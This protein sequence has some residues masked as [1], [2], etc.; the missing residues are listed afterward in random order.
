MRILIIKLSSL[1]DVIHTLPALAALRK[2]YPRAHLSWLVEP[3]SAELLLDHPALDQVLVIPKNRWCREAAS[4]RR[5]PALG[6]EFRHFLHALRGVRY[7]I[8]LDFQGLLKSGVL[9][10][11]ARGKRK[12]GFAPGKERGDIFLNEKV[13]YPVEL[14]HAVRRYLLLTEHLACP[15]TTPSFSISL[16]QQHRNRVIAL[17]RQH[18]LA[19]QQPLVLLHPG[20]RW[21]S[22][23]WKEEHW[24]ALGDRLQDEL[25][26][27]VVFTGS[28]EDRALVERI[29]GRMRAPGVTTVGELDLKELAFLQACAE[30]VV[31]P[32]SGPMHLATAMG[33]PVVALF[34]PTDPALTGPFGN[35]RTVITKSLSCRPCL[36]R[37]CATNECMH[38]ISVQEVWEGVKATLTSSH[39]V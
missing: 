26:A 3:E 34:G 20:T 19:C 18:H 9:T 32:D 2:A 5:W 22:K 27:Q 6:K 23:L 29:R 39:S 35:A 36:K 38:Q 8:V 10:G 28:T 24:A 1:G 7:D 25:E 4:L 17:L 12:V 21:Q 37:Q 11:L 13:P 15:V 14:L 30:V 31:T 33:T 16:S